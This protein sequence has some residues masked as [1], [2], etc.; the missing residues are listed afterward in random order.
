MHTLQR[1][2][3]LHNNT[4]ACSY[5][6]MREFMHEHNQ[7]FNTNSLEEDGEDDIASVTG[8]GSPLFNFASSPVAERASGLSRLDAVKLRMENTQLKKEL[9][10]FRVRASFCICACS[11]M[12]VHGLMTH[13]HKHVCLYLHWCWCIIT[14]QSHEPTRSRDNALVFRKVAECFEDD[15]TT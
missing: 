3:S 14:G 8:S 4:H 5:L 11:N 15:I 6:R 2:A 10:R 12:C 1:L 9:R 13:T 7:V